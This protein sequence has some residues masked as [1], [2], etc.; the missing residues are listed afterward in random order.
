MFLKVS[1]FVTNLVIANISKF[2]AIEWLL[3]GETFDIHRTKHGQILILYQ[4]LAHWH[5]IGAP[6]SNAGFHMNYA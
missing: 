1:S 3:C 5:I 2:S 4:C 6:F